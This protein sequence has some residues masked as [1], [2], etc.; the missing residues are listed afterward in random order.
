M[1]G[2]Y[3]VA[4]LNAYEIKGGGFR[5]V[6][7]VRETKTRH[8]SEVLET[9][10]AAKFWAKSKAYEVHA[11]EGYRLAAVAKKGEY[12]ANVWVMV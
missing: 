11:A 6:Y 10:E 5:G 8:A 7:F 1:P 2:T 12:Y 4:T 3:H 9:L